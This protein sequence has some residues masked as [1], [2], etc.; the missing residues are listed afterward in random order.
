[1]PPAGRFLV[2]ALM[3]AR[4]PDAPLPRRPDAPAPRREAA[5]PA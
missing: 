4:T 2:M 5:E 3:V 1:M